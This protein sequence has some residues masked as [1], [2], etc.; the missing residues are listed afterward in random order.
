MKNEPLN[1]NDLIKSLND[2][3]RDMLSLTNDHFADVLYKNLKESVIS[4]IR[5]TIYTKSNS[6]KLIDNFVVTPESIINLSRYINLDEVLYN[7][8]FFLCP[9]RIDN[10]YEEY[11]ILENSDSLTI[12]L[13]LELQIH[14]IFIVYI[15]LVYLV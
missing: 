9:I 2:N 13:I 3:I 11:L 12:F 6:E 10:G 7:G 5:N 4:A 14:F 15:M 1:L 8:S